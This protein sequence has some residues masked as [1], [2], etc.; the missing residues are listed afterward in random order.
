MELLEDL[1]SSFEVPFASSIGVASL[2]LDLSWTSTNLKLTIKSLFFK[3]LADCWS[4]EKVFLFL[5]RHYIG[6]YPSFELIDNNSQSARS[7]FIT[8]NDHKPGL[9]FDFIVPS[10]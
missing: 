4:T 5:H 6:T 2:V 1:F 8:Y 3:F 7:G 9:Y 10:L